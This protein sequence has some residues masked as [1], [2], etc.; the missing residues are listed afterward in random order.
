MRYILALIIAAFWSLHLKADYNSLS[1][2][3][4]KAPENSNPSQIYLKTNLVP[5]GA[6]VANLGAEF[7]FEKHW[8]MAV[9]VWYC[10]WK[11]TE[12]HSLKTIAILPEAR[13]WFKNNS[14]GSFLDLHINLAW[15]NA[16]WNDYRYQDTGQPLVGIGLGYGYRLMFSNRWGIEFTIGAGIAH[17]KYD[18]YFNV[19]NGAL[20]DTRKTTY[21]GI[22]RVGITFVYNLS[23][24]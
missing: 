16:R 4:T 6:G 18:R 7:S 1:L 20:I 9:N 23:G 12:R 17:T 2:L 22:D 10:P 5:W 15:Y 13:Y 8:S 24:L 21:M 11:I 3:Q 19:S 14:K